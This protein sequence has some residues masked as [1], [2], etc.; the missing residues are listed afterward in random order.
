MRMQSRRISAGPP[1]IYMCIH[2]TYSFYI[3]YKYYTYKHDVTTQL[4]NFNETIHQSIFILLQQK[5]QLT[6]PQL[7]YLRQEC[8]YYCPGR[9]L[10]CLVKEE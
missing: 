4:T 10:E 8:D 9:K 7:K 3:I 6:Q 5:L 2:F 1:C